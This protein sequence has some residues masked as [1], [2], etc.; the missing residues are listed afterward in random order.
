MAKPYAKAVLAM[1]PTTPLKRGKPILHESINDLPV[2]RLTQPQIFYPTSESRHFTRTDA[3]RVFSA[4]PRLVEPSKD[5]NDTFVQRTDP[6]VLKPADER[7][8]H[9]QLLLVAD[10]GAAS[11]QERKEKY[12]EWLKEEDEAIKARKEKEAEKERREIKK[13]A[14]ERFEF[15][16]KDV[17]VSRDTVGLDGRGRKGV[18]SRYGVPSMER[19]RGAVK[20]PTSVEA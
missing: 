5:G 12:N 19:K 7:I 16:F 9:P 17:S 15:R 18:G 6:S 3:G 20:I 4:A 10:G 11:P 8:P 14:T 1:L 2:H 13:V